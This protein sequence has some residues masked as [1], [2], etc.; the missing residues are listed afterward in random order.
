MDSRHGDTDG[1]S[2]MLERAKPVQSRFLGGKAHGSARRRRVRPLAVPLVVVLPHLRESSREGH[3]GHLTFTRLDLFRVA[4][5][6][7][8]EVHVI[9]DI[10]V[11]YSDPQA[12]WIA[13]DIA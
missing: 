1:N 11:F 6:H 13:A 5:L 3:M 12:S 4:V 10:H 2:N 9:I 7:H 8:G